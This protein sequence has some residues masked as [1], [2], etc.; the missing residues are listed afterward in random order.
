MTAALVKTYQDNRRGRAALKEHGD[1][2]PGQDSQYR[3]PGHR[4]QQTPQLF[5]QNLLQ[6]VPHD[7]DPVKKD[8]DTAEES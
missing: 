3:P 6:P 5:S 4:L 8:P 7:L 2:D 1:Q